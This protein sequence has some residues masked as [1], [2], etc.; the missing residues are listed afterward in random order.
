LNLVGS[1]HRVPARRARRELGWAPRVSYE[2]GLAAVASYIKEA[3]LLGR[4]RG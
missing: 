4:P 3:G 2:E 1:H